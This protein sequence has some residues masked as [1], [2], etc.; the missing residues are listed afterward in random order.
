MN[1]VAPTL[2]YGLHITMNVYL[3]DVADGI[4]NNSND[5]GI[6]HSEH[7]TQWVHC[8]TLN[9]EGNLLHRTAR[10][11]IGKHPHSLLLALE[12]TL[13]HQHPPNV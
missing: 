9:T 2:G 3:Q 10:R 7:I 8:S 5:F 11:Q 1:L 13:F 12:V 6:L 4:E